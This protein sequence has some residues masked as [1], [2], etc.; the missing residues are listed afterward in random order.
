MTSQALD[1]TIIGAG[2]YGLSVAVHFAERNPGADVLVLE[3]EDD[4]MQQ[5]SWINQAR[6]HNGYHYPRSFRTA[7]RSQVNYPSFLQD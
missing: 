5:A 4:A 6:I 3:S 1:F 2:F 7:F